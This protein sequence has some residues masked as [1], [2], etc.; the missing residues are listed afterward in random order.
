MKTLS[1]VGTQG[2]GPVFSG[3]AAV[4]R[5]LLVEEH[6]IVC[7]GLAALIKAQ[8]DLTLCGIAHDYESALHSAA[9]LLPNLI[10]LGIRLKGHDGLK[11][12]EQLKAQARRRPILVLSMYEELLFAPR[13]LRIG[14]SG[15]V[16]KQ[17]PTATLLVAIRKVLAGGTFVSARVEQALRDRALGHESASILDPLELLSKRQAQVYQLLGKGKP[18]VEI[19]R[20][21]RIGVKTV[22][23]HRAAI[24]ER[25]NL[26]NSTDLV[27]HAVLMERGAP[28]E[29]QISSKPFPLNGLP[30]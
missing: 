1:A 13:A 18:T 20:D 7:N 21:L 15:Y 5:L 27:L 11:L 28:A 8:P 2:C 24:I 29:V 22:E 10:V 9:N 3:A 17:E 30:A 12:L 4:H 19:A 6:P 25:L 16:M 14:A 26:K 23:T